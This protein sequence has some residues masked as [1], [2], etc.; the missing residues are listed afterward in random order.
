[1]GGGGLYGTARD[2]LAF[3]QMLMH[4]GKFNGARVLRPE[5]V[6]E[7][8]KNN[9][10]DIKIAVLKT[11]IP[12]ASPDVDLPQMFPGHDLKWG[13]SFLINTQQGPAGSARNRLRRP[14]DLGPGY[15][16]FPVP[17]PNAPGFHPQPPPAHRRG[18]SG[19]VRSPEIDGVFDQMERRLDARGTAAAMG[20]VPACSVRSGAG[21]AV[22][23]AFDLDQESVL[24]L[25][26]A[27]AECALVRVVSWPGG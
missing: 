9:M 17:D 8:S 3:L 24:G 7:M 21:R 25:A 12:T 20:R 18:R 23:A 16:S 2:Y 4:G 10:G 26:I 27:T 1:M 14:R 6:A 5:T 22:R 15:G 11:A 19:V 13:L